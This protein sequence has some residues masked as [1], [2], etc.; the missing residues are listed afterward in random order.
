MLI[1]NKGYKQGD[2]VSVKLSNGDELISGFESE[3]DDEIKLHRPLALTTQGGG[4]GMMPWMLLGADDFIT[5]KKMHVMAVSASKKDA[6]DQY[7]QGTSDIAL[8]A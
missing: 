5:L 1:L 6:A 3:T 4:L 7:T 8:V 2:V